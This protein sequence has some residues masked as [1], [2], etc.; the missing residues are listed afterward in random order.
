MISAQLVSDLTFATDL[1]VNTRCGACARRQSCAIAALSDAG[2]PERGR[3]VPVQ[4][5]Y[6]AEDII[7]EQGTNADKLKFIGA[8]TVKLVVSDAAGDY[9]VVNF[10]GAGNVLGWD[11]TRG[12]K[13]AISAIALDT[14]SICEVDTQAF[15]AWIADSPEALSE[16]LLEQTQ[17]SA[18]QA[19]HVLRLGQKS[20]LQRLAGFLVEQADRQQMLGAGQAEVALPMSRADIGSFLAMAVETVSRLFTRLQDQGAIEVERQYVRVIDEDLLL[21]LSGSSA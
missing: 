8:G 17:Q 19:S 4:H 5:L 7:H 10:L 16:F 14:V 21:E 9:Q 2:L 18:Y 1:P 13:H 6:H 12:A 20:A 15:L 3:P 11:R